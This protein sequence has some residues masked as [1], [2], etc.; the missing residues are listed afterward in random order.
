MSI[1]LVE[2]NDP[3]LQFGKATQTRYA[4]DFKFPFSPIQAFG[5]ALSSFAYEQAQ[6]QKKSKSA[7]ANAA[8]AAAT[9]NAT[10]GDRNR[11]RS[12][13][14][15]QLPSAAASV[16]TSYTDAHPQPQSSSIPEI[17]T[18]FDSPGKGHAPAS[19]LSHSNYSPAPTAQSFNNNNSSCP[20]SPANPPTPTTKAPRL[21][22]L[23][24][25]ISG[26]GGFLAGLTSPMKSF[27]AV[28]PV[29]TDTDTPPTTPSSDN[30]Q[31][32]R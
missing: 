16:S 6:L 29:T 22:A 12:F 28:L 23:A 19:S 8:K 30:F 32:K 13:Q 31:R 21:L 17:I 18:S 14:Q 5:I 25:T 10:G 4:L 27:R 15:N 11:T 26:E 1:F 9:L 20:P 2:D 7:E 3:S 24:R